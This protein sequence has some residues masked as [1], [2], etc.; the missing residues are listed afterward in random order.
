MPRLRITKNGRRLIYLGLGAYLVFLLHA[1]PASFLTRYILPAIP[2]ARMVKLQGV[3][4]SIWNGQAAEA[5]FSNFSLG[6][7]DWNVRSWGLLLGKLKLHLKFSDDSMQGTAYVALGLGG[8][9]S[10]EDVNMK[11][12]AQNLM[13]LMYGYPL[14]IAGE[15]RGNLRE[16]ALERGRV[17]QA[18]GRIVWQNAA[19]RAPQNIEMGDY[20]ITVEPVNLGSKALIKDQGRGP[21][22]AEITIFVKGSGDYQMNGWLKA[23]DPNQQSITE[24]LRLIGRG[25]NSGRY[26][27]RY[28]G[29]LRD[30][31]K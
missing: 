11:F 16:V 20:L 13:P 25:D 26:W 15:F 4:G 24:A 14:S 21:V 30:W 5:R 8:A 10:A 27:V 19:L 3:H 17:L 23:R 9:I 28:N 12:P 6:K 29:R 1:I 2:A 22:Q 18:Q 7:L 31:N